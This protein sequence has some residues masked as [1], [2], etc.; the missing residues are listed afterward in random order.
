MS[1][2]PSSVVASAPTAQLVGSAEPCGAVLPCCA[3]AQERQERPLESEQAS[4]AAAYVV[5]ACL[6][7]P[8]EAGRDVAHQRL[9]TPLTAMRTQ[10]V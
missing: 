4:R 6:A 2:V 10:V 9:A 5:V 8:A 7:L 3:I 1:V